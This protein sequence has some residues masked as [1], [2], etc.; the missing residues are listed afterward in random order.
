MKSVF[1]IVVALFVTLS[2]SAQTD[3]FAVTETGLYNVY[4]LNDDGFVLDLE[5]GRRNVSSPFTGETFDVSLR[6]VDDIYDIN[7]DMLLVSRDGMSGRYLYNFKTDTFSQPYIGQ[8]SFLPT[9]V[10]KNGIV[11]GYV[12]SNGYG[13]WS[14]GTL[15][16]GSILGNTFDASGG[17]WDMSDNGRLAIQMRNGSGDWQ[18]VQFYDGVSTVVDVAGNRDRPIAVS[19]DGSVAINYRY[20]DESNTFQA[21]TWL[22]TPGGVSKDIPFAS[23]GGTYMTAFD[24]NNGAVV[25]AVDGQGGNRYPFLYKDGVTHNLDTLV[26]SSQYAITGNAEFINNSGQIVAS[27]DGTGVGTKVLLTPLSVAPIDYVAPEVVTPISRLGRWDGETFVPIEERSLPKDANVRVLNHG[28]KPG[29][30]QAVLD[31]P[32]LKVWDDEARNA[33]GIRADDW[34][35]PMAAMM[36]SK[37]PDDVI[38]AY[39]WIDMSAT[40]GFSPDSLSTYSIAKQSQSHTEEAG[41]LLQQALLSAFHYN[42]GAIVPSVDRLHILGHSHGAKVSAVAS[43]D[44]DLLVQVDQLTLWDSPEA[45]LSVA[46]SIVKVSAGENELRTLFKELQDPTHI[47]EQT[48]IDNYVSFFGEMYDV[49]GVT[50]VLL[51]PKHLDAGFI[52]E[53]SPKHRYAVDWYLEASEHG[54]GFEWSATRPTV[55]NPLVQDWLDGGSGYDPSKEFVLTN[56]DDLTERQ[57]QELARD[58]TLNEL[59]KIGGVSTPATSPGSIRLPEQSPAFWYGSL[60]TEEDDEFFQFTYQFL[61]EGDGDQ[62][63]VWI[64]G[65]PYYF[66]TGV[67][68]DDDEQQV[69]VSIDNLDPG[70]HVLTLALHS[71]GDANA[72]ILI[73]DLQLVAVVPEPSAFIVLFLS[74]F[75]VF[76]RVRMS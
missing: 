9:K 36:Q 32:G 37:N 74:T 44:L 53:I 3:F 16:S 41:S 51:R 40:E 17:I 35:E 24:M 26:V 22:H 64:D 68:A 45:S 42:E 4:G 30:K 23:Q 60:V 52:E 29:Y 50:N 71:A 13:V 54:L 72:E 67:Y 62:L 2:I 7:G 19:N 43:V 55:E 61:A 46:G 33:E 56:L 49:T 70:F 8:A 65:V 48:Y 63:G 27:A 28:W 39:S 57:D 15:S 69:R 14:N 21:L 12:G 47:G 66:A 1:C 25:G 31:N 20:R 18:A 73:K 59:Y 58:V 38:L 6:G 34:L 75:L 10:G 11:G 76:R 5:S